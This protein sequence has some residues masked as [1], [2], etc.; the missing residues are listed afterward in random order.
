[1]NR[2]YRLIIDSKQSRK[3]STTELDQATILAPV[4]GENER[5]TD[6]VFVVAV[7]RYIIP[8]SR[9]PWLFIS[10]RI[11]LSFPDELSS[12]WENWSLWWLVG[13]GTTAPRL[14]SL[15]CVHGRIEFIFVRSEFH[16]IVCTTEMNTC[17]CII[18]SE[19]VMLID[20]VENLI[21]WLEVKWSN[22]VTN[23]INVFSWR[24]M[25][26]KR[27]SFVF[28]SSDHWNFQQKLFGVY[29]HV[30]ICIDH[31]FPQ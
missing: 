17:H 10:R 6:F 30:L 22:I 28:C 15:H 14:W 13:R 8:Y 18:I 7:E 27:E 3:Q 2:S 20:T 29:A 9:S 1:M 25:H 12:K 21:W 31:T 23:C 26:I 16:S 5:P 4:R 11:R 19:S 24:R